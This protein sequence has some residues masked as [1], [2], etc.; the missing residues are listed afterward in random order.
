ML[1]EW[2]DLIPLA[3]V[4]QSYLGVIKSVVLAFED[5]GLLI[6]TRGPN[7]DGYKLRL[8]RQSEVEQFGKNL[9][10]HS[11]KAIG[12]PLESVSLPIASSIVGL[13]LA[14][15]V[16][17]VLNN[18]IT[19][20]EVDADRPLFH[21]LTLPRTAVAS[22]LEEYNGRQRV[23]LGLL[24]PKEVAESLG[25]SERVLG[26]WVRMDL[27]R[28]EK[29]VIGGKKAS[30]LFQRK[31]LD[32]FLAK[33]VFTHEVAAMLGIVHQTVSKYIRK[34]IISPVAGRRTNEGGNR[35]LFLR[36]EVASLVSSAHLTQACI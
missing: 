21:S 15:L 11:V 33:Y 30:L 16:Q 36:D 6:P 1:R 28:G 24:T 13:P 12:P 7:T 27:I 8:Y 20:L 14:I 4:A 35:L 32:D 25:I 26:R 29:I 3:I 17:E 34:G 18:N 10:L 2:E 31:A 19:P 9:L 23:K 5:A 22:F